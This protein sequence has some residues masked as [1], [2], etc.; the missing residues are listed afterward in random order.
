[1]QETPQLAQQLRSACAIFRSVTRTVL[2]E[3]E[4][5]D[6]EQR[7]STERLVSEA[8]QRRSR[9]EIRQLRLFL[10]LIEWVSVLRYGRRFTS[11]D[12]SRRLRILG[13]LQDHPVQLIRAGFWGLRT[14][15]FLG[16]YGRREAAI[17]IGY[18]PDARGWEAFR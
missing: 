18:R 2:P 11:L 17:A 5:L 13:Y 8:L 6:P 1:M 7:E 14:L 12:R 10:H 4:A 9:G 3:T 15:A 16:Y